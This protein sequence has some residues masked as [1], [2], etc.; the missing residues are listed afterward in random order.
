MCT[1][2]LT[3]VVVYTNY[4]KWAK[5]VKVVRE[6]ISWEVLLML[7]LELYGWERRGVAR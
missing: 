6:C 2:K 5:I 7:T 4:E 1:M 3:G